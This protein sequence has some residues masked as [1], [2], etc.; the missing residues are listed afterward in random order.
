MPEIPEVVRFH[1]ARQAPSPWNWYTKPDFAGCI[2][3]WHPIDSVISYTVFRSTES[4][5]GD[6][7]EALLNGEYDDVVDRV[8]VFKPISQIVDDEIHDRNRYLV[9]AH[10]DNDD[11]VWVKDVESTQFNSAQPGEVLTY[12][13]NP[14]GDTPKIK[15]PC[16]LD[17][18]TVR[19][20]TFCGF[21]WDYPIQYP[22]FIGY[23]LIICDMPYSPHTGAD[24]DIEAFREVLNGTRGVH[25]L[26]DRFVTAMV[27]NESFVNKFWY[28]A[29]LVRLP[30]SGRVQIPIRH[31]SN[32]FPAGKPFQYLSPRS[33]WGEG[34]ERMMAAFAKWKAQARN[35]STSTQVINVGTGQTQNAETP[36]NNEI[37]LEFFRHSPDLSLESYIKHPEMI[38]IQFSAKVPSDATVIA[39]RAE[40]ELSGSQLTD[41]LK[42]AVQN[43]GFENDSVGTFVFTPKDPYMV[44]VDSDCHKKSSY[45]FAL[46]DKENDKFEPL[47]QVK[48]VTIDYLDKP[49]SVIRWGD[50]S[51]TFRNRMAHVLKTEE[52]QKKNVVCIEFGIVD[53]STVHAI[54]LYRFDDMPTWDE[55]HLQDLYTF[56]KQGNPDIGDRYVIDH[57]CD[58]VIDD[59]S[60]CDKAHYYA[61]V[62][63]DKYGNRKAISVFSLG[64][65]IRE[66]WEK[67][68]DITGLTPA[69]E[70]K[71]AKEDV[72]ETENS[73]SEETRRAEAR[74]WRERR[75]YSWDDMERIEPESVESSTQSSTESPALTRSSANMSEV[76]SS[77]SSSVNSSLNSSM[78]SSVSGRVK[79]RRYNWDDE[80]EP[81]SSVSTEI[82][83]RR[84]VEIPA[85]RSAEMPAQRSTESPALTRSSGNMPA[86]RSSGSSAV[87]SSITSSVSGRVRKR[88]Y[89]W[90]DEDEPVSSVSTEIPAQRS[91]EMSAQRSTE[92]PAQRSTESP[93]LTRSSGNMSVVRSSGS[94]A[95]NSSLTS[96]VSGRVKKRRYN[97]EDDEPVS[98][99]STEMPTRRSVEMPAQRSAEMP[100]QRS[101]ESPALTR[102]SGNMS[103]VRSSGSSAVNS[104]MTSSVSGRVRKR[105]YNWEDDEPVI[106][107]ESPSLTRSSASMSAVSS[108][109][110]STVNSSIRSSVSGRV[111]KR[112]Y[113]W[114]DDEPAKSES[115][116]SVSVESTPMSDDDCILSM[117]ANCRQFISQGNLTEPL[118]MIAEARVK[119]GQNLRLDAFEWNYLR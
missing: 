25:F 26:I 71:S 30:E 32:P 37:S 94:S 4:L 107:T 109:T 38:G 34:R 81:V 73:E 105:R 29:L 111:K 69:S 104:S 75:R 55:D 5:P 90:D 24:S 65:Q 40:S 117:L 97:W 76:S 118:K 1:F 100:A 61:A 10:L 19:V 113:S 36:K 21:E 102:S 78:T 42:E 92:M 51:L 48:D 96:S 28:Y 54:E 43:Q 7:C 44:I 56:E 67:L 52:I 13:S 110:S 22:D 101:T 46:Y 39:I 17:Y 12:W 116:E 33:G 45:A 115:V 99:V 93:A 108:S 20:G 47:E 60:A 2:L 95:V 83:A 15:D 77:S 8:D 16:R 91:V 35:S 31:T 74:S 11:I 18:C 89:N 70:Q 79:K 106:S 112:R 6:C 3:K 84:S 88:R 98:S 82:P 103:A 41:V 80:D 64:A 87:N 53:E 50:Q 59:I 23:E 58:G 86:V 68:S 66:D 72:S 27:D 63:V 49:E 119:Y 57:V 14:F 85:Q 114:E 9:L 62:S